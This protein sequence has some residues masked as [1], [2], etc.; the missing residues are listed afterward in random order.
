MGTYS[1]SS[2]LI[3]LA[4]SSGVSLI[5]TSLASVSFGSLLVSL[6]VVGPAFHWVAVSLGSCR[7]SS[8]R[9]GSLVCL[10]SCA[11]ARGRYGRWLA[12]VSIGGRLLFWLSSRPGRISFVRGGTRSAVTLYWFCTPVASVSSW[13]ASW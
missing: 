1:L 10:R 2:L 11:V 7:W 3:E 9:D 6:F 8:G 12:G 4:S 5:S 13:S